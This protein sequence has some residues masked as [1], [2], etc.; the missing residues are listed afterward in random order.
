MHERPRP[1]GSARA[2]RSARLAAVL[3]AVAF[4]A[5]ACGG[6]E[7]TSAAAAER[8]GPRLETSV[9]EGQATTVGGDPFDLG[10]LANADLVVWFWAPW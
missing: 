8:D 6:D 10:T 2:T 4:G 3:L 9:L 7:D 5:A 1:P